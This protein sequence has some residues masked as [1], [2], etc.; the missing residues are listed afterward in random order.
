MMFT[1]FKRDLS[2][3]AAVDRWLMLL[4]FFLLFGLLKLDKLKQE[5]R[6]KDD[7]LQ[8]LEESFQ[9]LEG[10]AKEECQLSRSQQERINELED[11]IAVKIDLCRRLENQ[12]LKLSEEANGKSET[13][14]NLQ[15]KVAWKIIYVNFM[16][17]L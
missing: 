7:A 8:K 9:N 17:L 12:L 2:T 16:F 6:F 11:H 10:K 4:I 5:L 1:K 3:E 13:C 14:L 15:K